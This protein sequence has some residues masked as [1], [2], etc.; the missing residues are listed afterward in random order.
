MRVYTCLKQQ[1]FFKNNY[2]I[3]AIRDEDKYAIMQWRN[4][5]I[6]ILRQAK[7]LTK[8]D[9][10]SYFENVVAKLFTQ[11]KPTQ[12]LF[13]FFENG[14]L[15][16]YG[17]LVHIDWESKNAEISFLLETSRNADDAT[18]ANDFTPYLQLLIQISKAEL[19]FFKL[20]TTFYNLPERM[21]Y[22]KIVEQERFVKEAV[23]ENHKLING[24][25][26]DV[27]IYSKFL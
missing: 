5:Q 14:K 23:L 16:G 15:I 11:E 10:E 1:T 7:P 25:L 8:A 13:S 22:K 27:Y 12:L 3:T 17:G 19:H 20:H 9:Q 4:E 21:L 26:E 6:D 18:F 24:Q 2:S